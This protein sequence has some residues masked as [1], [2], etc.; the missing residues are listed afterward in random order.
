MLISDRIASLI[1]AMLKESGGVLEIQRNDM[2]GRIGCSPSQINYVIRSRFSPEQG[3]AVESRR[4]G[5][6]Y[7]RIVQSGVLG[8]R[9]RLGE[10]VRR[11]PSEMSRGEALGVID[12]LKQAKLASPTVASVMA[13]AIRVTPIC[14]DPSQTSLMLREMLL[15]LCQSM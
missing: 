8:T 5:G 10:I 13:T 14:D 4:G 15:A 9:E 12:W 3:Y 6:G 1:S 7:V 11:L 2:A